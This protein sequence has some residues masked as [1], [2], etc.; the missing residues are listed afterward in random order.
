M[1]GKNGTKRLAQIRLSVFQASTNASST[2]VDN[3]RRSITGVVKTPL[4]LIQQP[5]GIFAC[6]PGGGHKF[7]Q[8]V[9]LLGARCLVIHRRNLAEQDPSGFVL[10]PFPTCSSCRSNT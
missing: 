6:I 3:R 9:L 4:L 10:N 7:L 5:L 1:S 8:D 2:P